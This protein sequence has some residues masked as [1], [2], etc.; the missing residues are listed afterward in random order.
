MEP[1]PLNAALGQIKKLNRYQQWELL[2]K[3]VT[4]LQLSSPETPSHKLKDIQG[5]GKDMWQA[6]DV[7]T[8]IQNERR[9]WER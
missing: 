2:T 4:Y 8:Y 1:N 5:V 7:D 3:L 9:S 6:I